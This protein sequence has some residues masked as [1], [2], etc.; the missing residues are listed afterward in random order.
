MRAKLLKRAI[1]GLSI[2]A[3]VL[4]ITSFIIVN[5]KK[6]QE[7]QEK[8]SQLVPIS[9]DSVTS[10]KLVKY[11]NNKI[12][13]QV[14]LKREGENWTIISPFRDVPESYKVNGMLEHLNDNLEKIF[15]LNSEEELYQY[16]MDSRIAVHLYSRDGKIY[17]FSIGADNPVASAKYIRRDDKLELG[18][19]PLWKASYFDL[20]SPN[21]IRLSRLLDLDIDKVEWIKIIEPQKMELSRENGVWYLNYD[22]KHLR[23]DDYQVRKFIADLNNLDI[24]AWFDKISAQERQKYLANA[25]LYAR[26]KVEGTAEP[27]TVRISRRE[28]GAI[29]AEVSNRP[30]LI[31]LAEH[32]GELL[33]DISIKRFKSKLVFADIDFSNLESVEV[34]LPDNKI[35]RAERTDK[36]WKWKTGKEGSADTFVQWLRTVQYTKQVDLKTLTQEEFYAKAELYQMTFTYNEKE[37]TSKVK[38][39]LY[40]R[41]DFF[42]R[43]NGQI[44]RG[45]SGYLK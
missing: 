3:L 1:I 27:L 13:W 15:K 9:K 8:A 17:S 45:L 7:S 11:K 14:T 20:S 37:K 4:G 40:A 39:N 2:L 32:A 23:A 30:P 34:K 42:W 25:I 29:F 22:N 6:K 44:F 28:K 26:I 5:E 21:D 10:I 12:N 18:L 36:G 43:D 16:G 38:L 31:A 35:L 33:R 24:L 19:L 41:D